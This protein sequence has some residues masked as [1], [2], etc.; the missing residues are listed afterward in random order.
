MTQHFADKK[1]HPTHVYRLCILTV[2][3]LSLTSSLLLGLWLI[4]FLLDI[5]FLPA[6]LY[7]PAHI[8][9]APARPVGHALLINTALFILF[10]L[11]H[12]IMARDWFKKRLTRFIPEAL[13]RSVY[14]IISNFVIALLIGL[15]EPVAGD[16]WHFTTAIG[17]SV[18]WCLCFAGMLLVVIA[19]IS[20][21]GTEL[22]G[23]RQ[24][25]AG[26]KGTRPAT[27][28]FVT[29]SVYKIVRHPMQL[30]VIIIFWA[31][32]HLSMSQLLF[33]LGSTFYIFVGIYFEEKSLRKTFP[34]TYPAYQQ[35]VPMLLPW[36]RPSVKKIRNKN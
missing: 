14:V 30:G 34:D 28:P 7:R 2:L 22:I 23:I 17:A 4:S 15:W 16:V 1:S 5:S 19:V 29:P 11:Q 33:A 24:A 32:P 3:C 31:T 18:M 12:S 8:N 20:I 26:F 9:A 25:I 13:E 27:L 36:P 35:Q 21:S 10:G 6:H